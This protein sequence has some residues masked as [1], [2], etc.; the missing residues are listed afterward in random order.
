MSLSDLRGIKFERGPGNKKYKAII[1]AN[2][3]P[4]GK[5]KSVTFGD[6][7]YQQY[8]DRIPLKLYS[9]LNHKDKTRRASYRSR[10][11]ARKCGDGVKC[12]NKKY[13]AAWFSYY[14]LW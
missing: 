3:S 5:Q 9:N 10:H 14:F 13:S 7:R 6:K 2:L 4:T 8:E 11:G 1:P 12:I